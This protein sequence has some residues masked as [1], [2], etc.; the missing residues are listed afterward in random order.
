MEYEAGPPGRL[1]LNSP[2]LTWC[3]PALRVSAGKSGVGGEGELDADRF[4]PLRAI[5]STSI[6]QFRSQGDAR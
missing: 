1:T 3:S 2:P 6:S 5:M 4:D